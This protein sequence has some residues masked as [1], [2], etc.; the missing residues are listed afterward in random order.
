MHDS[1]DPIP[2]IIYIEDKSETI[3]ELIK[4]AEEY[5]TNIKKLKKTKKEMCFLIS[6]LVKKLD[7]IQED[8]Q[9]LNEDDDD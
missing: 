4:I 3:K 9:K 5:A 7:L 1:K 2:G 6:T 8:F